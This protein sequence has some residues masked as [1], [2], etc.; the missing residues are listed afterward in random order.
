MFASLAA[1][2]PHFDLLSGFPPL[3]S[4]VAELSAVVSSLDKIKWASLEKA[5]ADAAE[6]AVTRGADTEEGIAQPTA[7]LPWNRSGFPDLDVGEQ[8]NQLTEALREHTALIREQ[9]QSGKRIGRK[10]IFLAIIQGVIRVI[11]DRLLLGVVVLVLAVYSSPKPPNVVH[12]V[13]TIIREVPVLREEA[14]GYRIVGK[15]NVVGYQAPKTKSARAGTLTLGQI[16][17]L[18]QKKKQ[19]CLV[20]WHDGNGNEVQGWVKS[21][22]LNRIVS[23]RCPPCY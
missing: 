7:D 22:Y 11:I 2:R 20:E 3:A 19:W 4:R 13:R 21:K 18:V 9:V 1:M 16:V 17:R 5:F 12:D 6:V 23:R 8:L 10:D 15:G 14:K